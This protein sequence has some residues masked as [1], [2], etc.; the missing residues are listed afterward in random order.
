MYSYL[1]THL[2]KSIFDTY[3]LAFFRHNSV[4]VVNY[5]CQLC[6]IESAQPSLHLRSTPAGEFPV[7]IPGVGALLQAARD[8]DFDSAKKCLKNSVFKKSE[9]V[10]ARDD[11]ECT[12]LHYAVK[13]S[14]LRL[15]KLLLDKGALVQ[16]SNILETIASFNNE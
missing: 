6:S 5:S 10:N 14:H 11:R 13:I 3:Y 1:V 8:G 7:K 4:H 9:D 15:T 2:Q 16:V 12:A